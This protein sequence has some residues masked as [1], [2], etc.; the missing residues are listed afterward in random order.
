MAEEDRTQRDGI[1][2]DVDVIACAR[3]QKL[4]PKP[5]LIT[6]VDHNRGVVVVSSTVTVCACI[7]VGKPAK[8]AGSEPMH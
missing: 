6:A 1:S 8:A 2:P 7:F 4:L 3:C 5:E